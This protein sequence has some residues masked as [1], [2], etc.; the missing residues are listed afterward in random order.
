MESLSK[1]LKDMFNNLL[2]ISLE[3]NCMVITIPTHSNRE[4]KITVIK[5]N[6]IYMVDNEQTD[7]SELIRKISMNALKLC[8]K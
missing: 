1:Q 4:K 6:N 7:E 8:Q 3:A 2:N 5:N